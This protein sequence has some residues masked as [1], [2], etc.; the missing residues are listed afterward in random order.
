MEIG[1]GAGVVRPVQK[2]GRLKM[3]TLFTRLSEI[4]DHEEPVGTRR[5]KGVEHGGKLDRKI[6]QEKIATD[7]ESR[8]RTLLWHSGCV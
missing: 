3:I 5:T 1:T 8:T 7:A 4:S 2:D 6:W